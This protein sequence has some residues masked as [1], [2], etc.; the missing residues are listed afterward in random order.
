MDKKFLPVRIIQPSR[1]FLSAKQGGGGPLKFFIDEKEFSS[2]S[3]N[4]IEDL[5]DITK[6]F[7]DIFEEFPNLPTVI[8]AELNEK[9]LSKSNRP[10]KLFGRDTCPIIG[11]NNIGEILLSTTKEGLKKLERKIK[12]PMGEE[13]K[14]NITAINE[15]KTLDIK[16]KTHNLELQ[17]VF[18]KSL[19]NNKSYLKVL[20]FDHHDEE[21]NKRCINSFLDFCKK[22]GLEIANISKLERI[23]IYRIIGA[24]EKKIVNISKHPSVKTLSFFPVYK[25]VV[26]LE[27]F[28][29]KG[30][31]K[32]P[33]PEE[34]KNYPIV[35]VIDSGVSKENPILS[36][37][38]VHQETFI[39]P[40]YQDTYH[41]S[42][43]AGI[44]SLGHHFNGKDVHP[45]SDPIKILDV[46]ISPKG[47]NLQTGEGDSLTEDDLMIRLQE[48]IPK[49]AKTFGVRI[50]NMSLGLEEDCKQENFSELAIFLDEL[51][52][53]NDV[54][55]VLPSGNYDGPSQRVWPP[56][57][58]RSKEDLLQIPGDSVRS[59]TVGALTFKERSDSIV[60]SFEPA[61][62]SC[63]GPGP[64]FITKPE[65]VHYSG[66]VSKLDNGDLDSSGQGIIST[67]SKGNMV[68]G[69][70]TSYSAPMVARTLGIVN[71]RFSNK[72]S[73][74]LVKALT[75]HSAQLPKN[76]GEPQNIFPYVGYGIPSSVDKI[77]SCSNSE[78]TLVFEQGIHQ[79]FNLDI[80]F[81]WPTSLQNGTGAC[82]GNVKMT[83]VA[84]VPLDS[85]FGSEYIRANISAALQKCKIDSVSGKEVWNGVTPE[86]PCNTELK[87]M[88]GKKLIEHGS[89]WKP[90]KRYEK[91]LFRVK[92]DKW[93]LRV[94]LLL[95]DN[96]EQDSTKPINFTL[97][98]TISDPEEKAP[99]YD[100]VV[101]S[102]RN[103]NILTE[104]ISLK[105]QIKQ[106]VKS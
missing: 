86:D 62:Y 35:G 64:C 48:S 31:N 9:A 79:G 47:K 27:A 80:P 104:S 4:L 2:H 68:E 78:I 84:H 11:T 105:S 29:D 39:P 99:V 65:L 87:K 61:S 42:F 8:K 60:K 66:N 101:N 55:I 43:V 15:I 18:K 46:Q 19:R 41:G 5:R 1:D 102:L 98:F 74:E 13:I 73:L 91:K 56:I 25:V 33:K 32:F 40:E 38:I 30:I 7:E 71:D 59:I 81:K 88:Y 36:P 17:E 85:G 16:E 93:R 24:D 50:W 72:P 6:N 37:W 70:G 83:L 69:V 45:D 106:K 44:V 49:L 28:K 12:D 3:N 76:L 22:E 58:P 96:F 14:S 26:P 100:E 67:D 97:I 52:E 54:L 92:A 94:E 57:N 95:R 63:K 51:Q 21:I 23:K 77:M 90:I 10:K 20:L 53:E 82:R 89:R 103:L 34:G 75:I